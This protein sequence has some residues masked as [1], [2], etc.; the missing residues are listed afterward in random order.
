MFI[1]RKLIAVFIS[2]ELST[3]VIYFIIKYDKIFNWGAISYY[4]LNIIISAYYLVMYFPIS[5]MISILT[6]KLGEDRKPVSYIFHSLSG[7]LTT[8]ILQEKYFVLGPLTF[9][10]LAYVD[11]CLTLKFFKLEK[12]DSV[13]I[14]K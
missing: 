8:I 11:E 13:V 10:L 4:E 2:M 6:K 7:L 3:A 14:N 1:I 12:E 5:L 9:L